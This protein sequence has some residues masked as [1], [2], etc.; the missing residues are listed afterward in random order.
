MFLYPALLSAVLLAGGCATSNPYGIYTDKRLVDTMAD[1]KY[2]AAAVKAD[3]LRADF[4]DAWNVGVYCYYGKVFLVGEAPPRMREKAV[5]MASRV[6]GV[7]SVVAHWFSP[8][9]GEKNDLLLR[10]ALRAN[11]IAAKGLNSTRIDVEINADRVVL[12]GVAGGESEK[13]LAIRT[14]RNTKGVKE[15]TS[16]LMLPLQGVQSI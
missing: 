12:L 8:A 16:Y 15:V 1:D 14:A 13:N 7:H 9:K 3:L 10:A 2:I 6:G 11:L 4:S 5:E